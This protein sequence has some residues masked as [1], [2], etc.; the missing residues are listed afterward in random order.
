MV[1]DELIG[2]TKYYLVDRFHL[3]AQQFEELEEALGTHT[4]DDHRYIE[5]NQETVENMQ[6]PDVALDK[7]T[8][9]VDTCELSLEIEDCV[10]RHPHYLLICDTF[11]YIDQVGYTFVSKIV[12]LCKRRSYTRMYID[13][14]IEGQAVQFLV[15][16]QDD[17][18]DKT[19]GIIG[20]TNVE[21]N[22]LKMLPRDQVLDFANKHLM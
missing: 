1:G 8:V 13:K 21:Y 12:E 7:N 22:T 4:D 2:K 15:R 11:G 3:S 14:E 17:S 10:G 9:Y 5:V 16:E 6:I 20:I 18:K 19:L